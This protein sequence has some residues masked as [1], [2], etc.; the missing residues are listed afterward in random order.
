[1]T[2]QNITYQTIGAA[3]KVHSEL[4]SGF[5]ERAY[6]RALLIELSKTTLNF[7]SEKQMTLLYKGESI[8]DYYIDVFVE[9]RVIIELKALDKLIDPHFKQVK[10][11]LKMTNLNDGLIINF[12]KKSLQY[13][14]VY[15]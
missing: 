13:Y 8:G 3:M 15:A 7:E 12:G 9:N 4:G 2:I 5:L 6:H 14:H 11:Y 1:M 10:H